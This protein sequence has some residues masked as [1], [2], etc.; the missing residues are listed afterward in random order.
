MN[1]PVPAVAA[2]ERAR[3][4]VVGGGVG[5]LCAAIRLAS[6]GLEVEV[7]EAGPR[8]GGKADVAVVDRV[9]FDT[10]PSLLTL[11][12]VFDAVLACAGTSLRAEVTLRR[13]DP[14]FRYHWP[15]GLTLDVFHEAE[16]TLEEVGRVLG[17]TPRAELA[18]FLD[19]TRHTWELAA[20]AFVLGP[21][22]GLG[23]LWRHRASLLRKLRD[24]DPWRTMRGA[25]HATVREP[26]LR[27]LLARYATYNGSDP[28]RAP[29]TLNCIAHVELTLGAWG[30]EGG[31]QA[32]VHALVRVAGRLGVTLQAGVP[33]AGLIVE[34]GR[35]RGVELA[36]GR[37]LEARVVV[38]NA[39]LAHV[40]GQ[41]APPDVARRLR[42]LTEP[43]MSGWTAVLRARRGARVAHQ[44][45]FPTVYDE[46]F[47][48]LFDR[49]R[50][51][52]DPTVYLCAQEAAHGRE[53]WEAHEPLF[54]MANAPAE[55]ADARTPVDRWQEL[56]ERV[57][58]RAWG[59]GLVHP[60]D[61]VVWE[62]S[63]TDL[64]DRFPGTRGA[65]YGASS[66][67]PTAAFLRAHN[68]TAV[69]GLYLASGSVHPGGGLP[70]CASS[71]LIAAGCALEDLP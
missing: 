4:V 9:T 68:R 52:S 63:P 36:D 32:L 65:L 40:R 23:T 29:A 55:P 33:V 71:G 3:A 39:D 64:A 27:M 22:P 28:R 44:V 34:R 21:P 57:L 50:P 42:G 35:A 67:R 20:D 58:Q 62:R 54:V 1:A 11:P 43:S 19:R 6:A 41:L 14:A 61:A 31:I 60:D 51:P 12:E 10:G 69:P 25:I 18:T 70:L 7:V 59:A 30:V 45:L 37:R 56:K 49:D 46:E 53:G 16:G 8:F 5:G 38:A 48:D 2:R 13:L 15:D 17:A 66:N 26:H 47:R 24:L